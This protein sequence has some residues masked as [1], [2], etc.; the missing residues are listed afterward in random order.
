MSLDLTFTQDLSQADACKLCKVREFLAEHGDALENAT[1][2]LGGPKRALR[3]RAFLG[4]IA[5]A[6]Q[7]TSRHCSAL[8][9]MHRLLSLDGVEIPDSEQSARFAAIDPMDPVVHHLCL[10][11]DT[12][13]RLLGEISDMPARHGVRSRHGSELLPVF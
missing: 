13:G 1:E 10:L 3:W 2:R 6:S 4:E 5:G 12:L 8:V 11:A 9:D 7:L